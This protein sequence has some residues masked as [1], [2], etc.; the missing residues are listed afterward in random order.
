MSYSLNSL[1]GGYVGEYIGDYYSILRGILG[2]QTIAHMYQDIGSAWKGCLVKPRARPL[3]G[4]NR[5][6]KSRSA[7]T[8]K[9]PTLANK[10]KPFLTG[11]WS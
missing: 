5:R 2:V 7:S 4:R 11:G 10:P 6:L 1:R 8:S 9:F 3:R